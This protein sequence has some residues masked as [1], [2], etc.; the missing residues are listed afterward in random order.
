MSNLREEI[1]STIENCGVKFA[2]DSILELLKREQIAFSDWVN[3]NA[4]KYPTKIT[5]SE[6]LELYEASKTN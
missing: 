4:Y 6:L 3:V 1:Q 5:T 2:T